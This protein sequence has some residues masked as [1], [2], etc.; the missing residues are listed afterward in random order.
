MAGW[1]EERQTKF[2]WSACRL[3]SS[4][5]ECNTDS[6]KPHHACLF[7]SLARHCKRV[8]FG[9]TL[10]KHV[11]SL[12]ASASP[13][14]IIINCP[15]LSEVVIKLW[16]CF[17]IWKKM[18]GWICCATQYIVPYGPIKYT[19]GVLH[20]HTR[21]G[22]ERVSCHGL[23]TYSKKNVTRA[24]VVSEHTHT[25]THTHTSRVRYLL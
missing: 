5:P 20:T 25:H 8:S 14:G 21:P 24:W 2:P 10:R 13:C 19:T 9:G 16:L 7:L 6:I 23:V 17:F 18:N 4:L 11:V 1:I 3:I 12:K 22:S 15:S